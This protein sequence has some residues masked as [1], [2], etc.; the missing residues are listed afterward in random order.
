MSDGERAGSLIVIL[1]P[2]VSGKSTVAEELVFREISNGATSDLENANQIARSMVK[3]FGMSRLGRVS[4]RDQ[5]GAAFLPGSDGFEGRKFSEQTSR[6]IDMEVRK[7]IDDA[8][9]EVRSILQGRK[10]ALVAVA[11]RLIEQEVIDGAELRQMID[12][13]EPGPRLVP[14]SLPVEPPQPSA[15]GEGVFSPRFPAAGEE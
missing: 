11:Q 8:T 2:D 13:H 10:T 1:G 15:H 4:F 7:I 5:Q 3:E 12:A 14:G 9:A 6:E